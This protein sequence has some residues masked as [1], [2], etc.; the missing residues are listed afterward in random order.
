M[1]C[2]LTDLSPAFIDITVNNHLTISF[3]KSKGEK[4]RKEN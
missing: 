1:K 4:Q 2:H 3:L